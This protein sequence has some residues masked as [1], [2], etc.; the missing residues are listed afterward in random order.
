MGDLKWNTQMKSSFQLR[1]AKVH[2]PLA[3]TFLPRA[4]LEGFVC[5]ST[6]E[7]DGFSYNVALAH[8]G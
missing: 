4:A 8:A 5:L 6:V 7:L 2:I 1:P 3:V